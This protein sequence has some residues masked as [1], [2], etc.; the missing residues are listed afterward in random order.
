MHSDIAFVF[1]KHREKF[2]KLMEIKYVLVI[3]E[4]IM[5]L[6]YFEIVNGMIQTN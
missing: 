1:V 3:T 6:F 4:L 2:I 5:L